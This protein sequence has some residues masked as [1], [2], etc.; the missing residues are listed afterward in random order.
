[1][2]T[3]AQMR[4]IS[5]RK[6]GDRCGAEFRRRIPARKSGDRLAVPSPDS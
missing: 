6:S 4:G 5:A 3:A 2:L 1:L